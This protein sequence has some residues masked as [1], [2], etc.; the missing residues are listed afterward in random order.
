[1]LKALE[2]PTRPAA[3]ALGFRPA[4]PAG[5]GRLVLGPEGRL[6]RIVEARDA[7][8]LE[9]AIALCN[10]GAMAFD[11]AALFGLLARI[12]NANAKREY[13]LTDA[14]A[15]ARA[16]GRA[17]AVVEADPAEVMG[18][19]SRA[20]LAEAER[21]V[22]RELR[23]RAMAGGATLLDPDTVWLSFDTRLGRDVTVGPNVA[24]GPGVTVGDGA[25]IRGFCHIA[26]AR[27]GPGAVVGPFAR[28][29]PGARIGKGAHV[30]NFVEI[31]N[32]DLGAGAKA[33]HLAYLG[34]ARIGAAANI[35]AGTITCNYDGFAKHATEIGEGAF[36]GSNA[37]LVAPVR[38]GARAVVGAGSVIAKD[39]AA[40]AL[41]V[42]RSA[43]REIKGWTRRRAKTGK[44]AR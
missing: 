20:E 9:R 26:G 27:I 24:F 41:A 6:E 30:G 8:A 7:G 19:N 40:D 42:T 14:V 37:A 5:Y 34:D 18:I 29:R 38:I 2:G 36:I 16:R 33:N 4:D 10:A 35:G 13:Y 39:V 12:G 21:A 22:Q 28:L 23:A 1:M 43:Q 11:G 3:V 44:K 17:C 32:A 31:K 25:E 15:V